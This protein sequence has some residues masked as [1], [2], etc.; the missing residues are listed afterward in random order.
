MELELIPLHHRKESL[1]ECVNVLNAEW[2]RSVPARVYSLEKSCDDLPC[3]LL[4]LLDSKVIGHSRILKVHGIENACLIESVVIDKSLR[5]KGYGRKLMELTENYAHKLGF[6]IVFLN[7]VDKQDFYE[8]LGYQLS[9]PVN[10]LGANAHRVSDSFIKKFMG[11][12]LEETRSESQEKKDTAAPSVAPPAPPPPPTPP[13]PPAPLTTVG[14]GDNKPRLRL[15]KNSIT[16]MK[17]SL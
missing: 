8:H 6:S 9:S 3:S 14:G 12:S 1:D 10:S 15:I 4:L 11:A 7:T 13:L 2:P 5:G 17:K 16:W